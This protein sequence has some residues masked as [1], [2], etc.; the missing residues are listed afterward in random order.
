MKGDSRINIVINATS[1]PTQSKI[2]GDSEAQPREVKGY[3]YD[4][5]YGKIIKKPEEMDDVRAQV[6]ADYQDM[7]EKE[8]VEQLRKKY[9]FKVNE[10]ILATVNK[11]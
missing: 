6:T 1:L 2:S 5:T 10:D 9:S 7:L 8:W 11:H 4:S 3:P